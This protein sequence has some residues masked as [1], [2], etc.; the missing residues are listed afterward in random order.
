MKLTKLSLIIIVLF[1]FQSCTKDVD[2]DQIDDASIASEYISTLVYF[3]LGPTDFLNSL[4]NDE[5][6][7]FTTD[8]VK[9]PFNSSSKTDLIKAEF[10]VQTNNTFNRN[11]TLTIFFYN[12]AEEPIYEL[13]KVFIMANS[14]EEETIL[15]IFENDIDILFVAK[16]IGFAMEIEGSTDGSVILPTD[17]NSLI[18]QSAVKLYFNFKTQ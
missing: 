18:L 5:E 8:L 6:I 10:I 9:N 2:F 16:K 1:S 15:T 17:T 7:E 3:D 4:N 11:F 12:D 13:G 14:A